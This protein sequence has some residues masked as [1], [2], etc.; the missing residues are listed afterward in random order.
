MQAFIIAGGKG[1]RLREITGEDIPKPMVKMCGVPLLERCIRNLKHYGITEIFMSVG[2]LAQK[3]VDYFGSGENFG[4]HIEYIVEDEPLG[5]AGALFY[6]KGR[7]ENDFV[8]I[9]GDLLFDV[10]LD[11]MISYHK[12]NDAIATLFTHP[13]CHPYDSDIVITDKNNRVIRFDYKGGERNYYYS[14]NVNAGLF[15]INKKALDYITSLSKI[16]MEKDFLSSLI[17]REE[18]VFAYKSPEYIRDMGTPERFNQGENDLKNNLVQK[19]SLKNKQK[20]I[21]LDRDGTI[22]RYKGFIRD[23]KDIELLPGVADAIEL[24]NK[25]EYLA[26]AVSN[27]P[28][29]ARGEASFE[30]V[31]NMFCKIETLLGEEGAYLYGIYYCPHHPHS[32]YEGE[33]KALKI[34]CD[35]RKPKIG[36]LK[37]AEKNFNLDLS[38][39][40]IIGD[41]NL[42]IQ[43]GLNAGIKTIRVKTGVSEEKQIPADFEGINLIDCV[44]FIKNKEE[45]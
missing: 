19:R 18:R 32:G 11:K 13:N 12:K 35:C 20:A 4:V 22:N 42:D 30:D 3:I 8:M 26:I 15:V 1:T 9:S 10:D 28:V 5:S 14:N 25:S 21:F 43:T 27:Q 39:C 44:K 31:D 17:L 6:V 7:I 36:L 23:V 37:Q 41:S 38:Q 24:I 33:V 2:Y 34:D 45:I 40:Y 16:N 29:I